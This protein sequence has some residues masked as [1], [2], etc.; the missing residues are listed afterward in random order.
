MTDICLC[1][2]LVENVFSRKVYQEY[3]RR[4]D[5]VQGQAWRHGMVPEYFLRGVT[6]YNRTR[7][8]PQPST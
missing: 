2:N 6:S 7:S 4:W 5:S 1:R 3:Q 8:T